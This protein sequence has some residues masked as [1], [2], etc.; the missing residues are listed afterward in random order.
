MATALA[1]LTGVMAGPMVVES[2]SDQDP[3]L[4]HESDTLSVRAHLQS[5]VNLVA[6][7][8]L[9]WDLAS[10]ATGNTTFDPDAE[11]VESFIEPGFSF[12]GLLDSQS[13]LFGRVS[14]VAS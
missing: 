3:W 11:W 8:N 13:T 14:T 4:L 5:G 10:L 7:Q 6:E 2:R 12:E 9:F 1:G